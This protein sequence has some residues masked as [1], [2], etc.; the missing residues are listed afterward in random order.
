MRA[1]CCLL[2]VVLLLLTLLLRRAPV[3]IMRRSKPTL[4]QHLH[5][6]CHLLED[7][8]SPLL[9]SMFA[10]WNT[11]GVS[12]DLLTHTSGERVYISNGKV[13]LSDSTGWGRTIPTFVR[14]IQ[15][16]SKIVHLPDII[17]PLNPADEP[18]AA[19]KYGEDPRPLISFCKIPGFSDVLMPNT[20]EGRLLAT[21]DLM[22]YCSC[23]SVHCTQSSKLHIEH[24][25]TQVC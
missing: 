6:H 25:C 2:S 16:I 13:F 19:L 17:L 23:T 8:Y 1:W 7:E 9:Q 18:Q 3:T 10:H 22:T 12:L 21:S 4:Q 11:S 5:D 24:D 15:H 14:Y 20:A